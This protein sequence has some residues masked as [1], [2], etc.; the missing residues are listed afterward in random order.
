MAS[1]LSC[2]ARINIVAICIAQS[3]VHAKTLTR[4]LSFPLQD[5]GEVVE[6]TLSTA[7][8]LHLQIPQLLLSNLQQWLYK[9]RLSERDVQE[10]AVRLENAVDLPFIT[11]E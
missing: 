9:V 8:R 11:K 1:L 6:R 5:E 3:Y 7:Q 2:V 4:S 10:D